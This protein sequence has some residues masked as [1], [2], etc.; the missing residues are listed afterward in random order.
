MYYQFSLGRF[1]SKKL[2]MILLLSVLTSGCL[3]PPEFITINDN[4][5]VTI[6]ETLFKQAIINNELNHL[7]VV[8]ASINGVSGFEFV[9]DTGAAGTVIFESEKTQALNIKTEGTYDLGGSGNGDKAL[10]KIGV[11]VDLSIGGA[12]I[13]GMAPL[14]MNWKDV[15]L[16][17]SRDGVY[18]D[19]IIGY[20]LFSRFLVDIDPSKKTVQ[21]YKDNNTSL[22]S[23]LG[24]SALK[25]PLSFKARRIY[26]DIDIAQYKD[27]KG[28]SKQVMIDSGMTDTL[29][30]IK[31]QNQIQIPANTRESSST[32]IQGDTQHYSA[33]LASINLAGV[34]I[35]DLPISIADTSGI[36]PLLG[37][38]VLNRF[39][40]IIDYKNKQIVLI[41]QRIEDAF[42]DVSFG[43]RVRPSADAFV[44]YSLSKGSPAY[45]AGLRNKDKIIS[46]NSVDTKD[47][48]F[49]ELV[50]IEPANGDV[51]TLC[52]LREANPKRCIEL[53]AS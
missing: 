22:L 6:D 16:F 31:G 53:R 40:Q 36:E 20:D 25:L 51:L 26:T 13:N 46:V 48:R 39:R 44:A 29:H 47:I 34:E 49:R 50:N 12:T 32:G 27:S 4:A 14:I 18:I 23:S 7:V 38:R 24:S 37:A 8:S 2:A 41:P 10:A 19:G 5:V 17:E 9:L 1:I 33:T 35:N 28:F 3:S 52:Y 43:L 30:L 15:P 42:S 11:D 21:L 45:K